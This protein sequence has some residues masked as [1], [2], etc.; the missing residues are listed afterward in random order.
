MCWI[1]DGTFLMGSEDFYPEERP[2]RDVGVDGF[3]IDKY[4]VT[5]AEF[6]RFVKATG[7]VTLAERPL[8]A[9]QYPDA[10]PELLVPGALVF[11]K[12]RA[13]VDL[14]D[15][16]NWWEYVPGAWWKQPEG[17]SSTLHGRDRH[18]VTQIAYEDAEAYATWAGKELPTE[19]EW[20]LAARGG[21]EGKTFVWEM[22]SPRRTR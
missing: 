1:R 6:R 16:R 15:Y 18:P 12:A 19:A 7:Y 21:P 4:P 14:S 11:R 22:S 13:P 2:I 3:W 20:E 17:P 5:V 9:A 10:D 8:D